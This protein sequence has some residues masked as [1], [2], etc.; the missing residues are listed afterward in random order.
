MDP[1]MGAKN[2]P[3]GPEIIPK[4]GA[5]KWSVLG[6]QNWT[7]V[8]SPY[9]KI[10]RDPIWGPKTGTIFGAKNWPPVS[11]FCFPQVRKIL[12]H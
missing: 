7:P 6:V 3:L 10:I 9:S 2:W 1:K 8:W 12:A 5:R 11:V 4:M